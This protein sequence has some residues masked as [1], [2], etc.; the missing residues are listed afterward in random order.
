MPSRFS[1]SMECPSDSIRTVSAVRERQMHPHRYIV[2]I[3]K[4]LLRMRG[5][6]TVLLEQSPFRTC[7]LR[8]VYPE[9]RHRR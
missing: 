9:S 8:I 2:T 7:G 5:V 3:L 1:A 6:V 4:R